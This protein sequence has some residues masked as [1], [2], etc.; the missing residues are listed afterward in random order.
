MSI[1]ANLLMEYLVSQ[2]GDIVIS[3]APLTL[4][5]KNIDQ[6][7]QCCCIKTGQRIQTRLFTSVR[8]VKGKNQDLW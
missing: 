7:N 8:V 3:D 2:C 4:F 1:N 6:V 5:L